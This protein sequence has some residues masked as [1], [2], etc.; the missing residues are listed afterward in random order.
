MSRPNIVLTGLVGLVGSVLFTAFCILVIVQGWIPIILTSPLVGWGVFLFLAIF[1]VAEIPVM[2][3]GMRRIAASANPRAKYVALL[4][5][6]GFTFF[7]S[8]YAAPF[9]LLTG[10]VWA[11]AALAALSL[12]RFIA[13][14]VFLPTAT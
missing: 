9:I 13:A 11:G 10:N 7:A 12:A 3:F 5:N 4:T 8:V 6:V 2:I 14:V 1:S